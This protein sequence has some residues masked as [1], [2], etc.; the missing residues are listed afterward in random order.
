MSAKPEFKMRTVPYVFSDTW[1]DTRS[2]HDEITD[3]IEQLKA[4][5][6]DD[7]RLAAEGKWI[8]EPWTN[9]NYDRPDLM[10]SLLATAKKEGLV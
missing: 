6:M 8:T 3:P 10:K 7:V 9:T 5:R 2:Y 1:R 4:C